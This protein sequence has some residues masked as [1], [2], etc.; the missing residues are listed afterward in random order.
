MGLMSQSS[1]LSSVSLLILLFIVCQL[2]LRI[3]FNHLTLDY[4]PH[5]RKHMAY[6]LTVLFDLGMWQS[7]KAT[8]Y[9]TNASIHTNCDIYQEEYSECIAGSRSH[10]IQSTTCLRQI[11]A[12]TSATKSPCTCPTTRAPNAT[13]YS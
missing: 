12:R 7:Q 10:S 1:L 4:S 13:E 3:Y 6:K 11:D 9:P 2:N 5:Y 8:F